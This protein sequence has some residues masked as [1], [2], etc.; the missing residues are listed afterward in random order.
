M[1]L[2][3]VLRMLPV[4]APALREAAA[5]FTDSPELEMLPEEKIWPAEALPPDPSVDPAVPVPD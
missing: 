2:L 5:V 4:T 1:A 3:L